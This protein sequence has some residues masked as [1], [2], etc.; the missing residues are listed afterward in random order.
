MTSDQSK[1]PL[2]ERVPPENYGSPAQIRLPEDSELRWYKP[3][4]VESLHLMGWRIIYFAPAVG[5]IAGMLFWIPFHP[6]SAF[7]VLGY[8][9]ILLIL[10][11]IP[12]GIALKL[13]KNS[14]RLRTEPFCIHCG[15]DLTGLP[16][17]HPCP[18]CGVPFDLGVIEEYRRDPHWFIERHKHHQNL[19]EAPTPF[20]SGAVRS[21]KR[22][23]GT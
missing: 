12:A 21:R 14:I 13:A 19:P 2:E 7:M 17:K 16:D 11:A 4:F 18:E 5:I 6:R 1:R 23:D 20:S 3:S 15:Y 9:K 8:W 10:I 22:R